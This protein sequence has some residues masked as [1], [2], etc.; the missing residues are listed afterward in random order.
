M[1]PFLIAQHCPVLTHLW[2]PM[3]YCLHLSPPATHPNEASPLCQARMDRCD[4]EEFSSRKGD[5][6]FNRWIVWCPDNWCVSTEIYFYW[7]RDNILRQMVHLVW[8]WVTGISPT[9]P[10]TNWFQLVADSLGMCLSSRSMGVIHTMPGTQTFIFIEVNFT[11]N[12]RDRKICSSPVHIL[13]SSPV[14]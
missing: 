7:T 12:R 8:A 11:V 2:V 13:L 5:T 6:Y 1:E 9:P 14:A 3:A 4:F 10:T